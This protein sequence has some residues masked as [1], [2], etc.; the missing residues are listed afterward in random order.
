M[1]FKRKSNPMPIPHRTNLS[2][3]GKKRVNSKH[4]KPMKRAYEKRLSK[5]KRKGFKLA[6]GKSWNFMTEKE[7]GKVKKKMDSGKYESRTITA[8]PVWRGE[9]PR[10]YIMLRRVK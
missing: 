5:L 7:M 1:M 10:D 2:R 8:P 4:A 6:G 3:T 9:P